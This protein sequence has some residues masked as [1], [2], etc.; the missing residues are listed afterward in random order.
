MYLEFHRIGKTMEVRA[1]DAGDGLEV[2]FIAPVNTP[3]SEITMIAR[4]KLGYVRRKLTGELRSSDED[5]KSQKRSDRRRGI[6][7]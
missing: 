6:I 1:V 5:T 2:S 3:E 4:R 7:V